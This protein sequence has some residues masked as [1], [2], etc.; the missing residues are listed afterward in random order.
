MNVDKNANE[1][2]EAPERDT[3]RCMEIRGRVYID[4]L[5]DWVVAHLGDD[6]TQ[7]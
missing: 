3:L 2:G 7:E 5:G 1:K 6:L 4:T